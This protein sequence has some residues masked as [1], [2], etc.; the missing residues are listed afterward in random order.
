M[1]KPGK[2]KVSKKK[3]PK[4]KKNFSFIILNHNTSKFEI[5]NDAS[6]AGVHVERMAE[7]QSDNQEDL[8]EYLSK[9]AIWQV[10]LDNLIDYDTD[11]TV[12]P[13]VTVE[14]SEDL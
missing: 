14:E 5:A 4:E 9:I 13:D 12:K 2:K 3:Q 8:E 6:E 11:F 7:S 1:K 10:T